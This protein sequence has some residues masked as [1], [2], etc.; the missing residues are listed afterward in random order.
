MPLLTLADAHLAYGMAPLLDGAMLT[1][2]ENERIGLIGRNGTGK[3]S[4]LGVIAGTVALDDGELRRQ[5]GLRARLVPQE[6]ALPAAPT[7]RESLLALAWSAEGEA[8]FED[9]RERWRIEASL[10]EFLHRF[11]VDAAIEPGSASGGERKRAALALAFALRPDLILL[12]EPTNHLDIDGIALLEAALARGPAAIVVT[13][14]RWFLD[15]FATRIVELDRGVLAVVRRQLFRLCPGAN[16]RARRRGDRPPPLRQ[17]LGA[18]GSL[19]TA[20]HRGAPHAQPGPRYPAREPAQ[21]ARRAA[22]PDR[23]R[24]ARDRRG[25]AKR[26]ARRRARR[27]RQELR[28]QDPRERSLAHAAPR[29]PCRPDRSQRGR[30]IHAAQDHP[31]GSRARRGPLAPG[32]ECRARLF[33]PDARGARS[34]AH[35]RGNREPGLGVDRRERGE[36]ARARLHGGF[37]VFSAAREFSGA[38]A[39]GRGAEPPAARASLRAADQR[40]GA[41]RADQRPRPRIAGDA[42]SRAAGLPG[43]ATPGKPRPRVPRQHRHADARCR[44]RR[45][46]ARV[47]RGLQR[48]AEPDLFSCRRARRGF[49]E[50]ACARS[51]RRSHAAS[52][53][54]AGRGGSR[55]SRGGGSGSA[56]APAS[57]SAERSR[58]KLTYKEARELE[59][60]PGRS[61]RS[62]PS[63]ARSPRR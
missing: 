62:K 31:R 53:R 16:G 12:D 37:P 28:R 35:G 43:D 20:R 59:A 46:M 8:A 40:A 5:D 56:E 6:P 60:L 58:A 17:I 15:R 52:A 50:R 47:R 63:S 29:R 44:G 7:L 24:E 14:D 39:L 19:D 26:P 41:R 10:T 54:R 2:Q 36:K 11:E 55:A 34:G 51:S 38:H 25:R 22:R 23:Q 33:R 45:S 21:G 30:E 4:L 1:V 61:K 13:H 32:H 18:G 42:G 48:L 27:R 57:R 3:S 9:D 49:D